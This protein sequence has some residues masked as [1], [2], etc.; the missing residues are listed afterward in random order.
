[1]SFFN[2]KNFCLTTTLLIAGASGFAQP[3]VQYDLGTDS[4]YV[5]GCAGPSPCACPILIVGPVTGSFNLV[6]VPLSLGPIFE[7]TVENI[8]WL[9]LTSVPGTPPLPVSGFG[10]FV[11]DVAAD[12]QTVELTLTVAGVTQNYSSLG[13]VPA[14]PNFPAVV[15]LDVFY[16]VDACVYNGFY[17]SAST[18]VVS[19][20]NFRRGDCNSDGGVDV[21]DA[22]SALN[23][24]FVPGTLPSE[25]GDACDA[26]DDGAFNIADPI[27][28]L[29]RLFSGAPPLPPPL[30]CDQDPTAD[31]LGCAAFPPC[32]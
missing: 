8:D 31:S 21:A 12:T 26:N 5:T 22:V 2:L 20:P 18:I 30:N 29:N 15:R 11:I 1:M 25:C 13:P 7:Y 10:T 4:S 16:Q 14:D 28:I 9:V 17:T 6:P 27:L 3:A 32:P 19:P 23:Q 24:L